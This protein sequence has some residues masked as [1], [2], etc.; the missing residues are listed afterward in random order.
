MAKRT[1]IEIQR[2]ASDYVISDYGRHEFV[3]CHDREM[4]V[5]SLA[6]AGCTEPEVK[7][8]LAQLYTA[9]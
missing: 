1:R 2:E 8:L 3:R 5:H 9:S 6:I 4:L 7:L